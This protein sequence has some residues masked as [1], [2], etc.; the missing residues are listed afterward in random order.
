MDSEF[1]DGLR[2]K[3]LRLEYTLISYNV[4]EGIIAV[5]ADLRHKEHSDA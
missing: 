3:A 1:R 2:R 4:L 5:G